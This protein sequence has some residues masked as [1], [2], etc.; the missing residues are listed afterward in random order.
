LD[1]PAKLLDEI[2]HLFRLLARAAREA[3]EEPSMT[4]TQR[5]ALSEIAVGG[6][7][8]LHELAERMTTTAPTA[9]RAVEALVSGGFV[10]RVQDPR[11]RRAVQ[12]ALSKVGRRYV[13]ARRAQAARLVAPAF[14]RLTVKQRGALVALLHRLNEELSAGASV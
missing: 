8:R 6:P 7:F 10:V 9:S 2:N 13:D 1:E 12:I 14:R 11:D 5:L 3:T 4:A